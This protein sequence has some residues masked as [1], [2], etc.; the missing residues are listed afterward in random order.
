MSKVDSDYCI[1]LGHDYVNGRCEYCD[2]GASNY[3]LLKWSL[4]FL[5]LAE[6]VSQWSKDPSTKV[7]AVIVEGRNN[8]VSIG[9][10][11]FAQRMKDDPELYADR[12]TKYSRVVHGEINA[13]IFARRPVVGCT[14]YTWPFLP[15]DRC[16]VQVI[17]AGI[18]EVIAP[19]PSPDALTRWGTAFDKTRAYFREAE[20]RVTEIAC[21]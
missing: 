3:N 12:E 4:R 20:V 16:A 11:G 8:I 18:T 1:T 13:M 19:L 14:L 17:Q 2:A 9:Y 7:G 5:R 21:I 10:N 15:C 6:F